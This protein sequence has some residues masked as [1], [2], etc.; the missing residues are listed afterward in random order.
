MAPEP[1]VVRTSVWSRSPTA[2]LTV[3][4]LALV[5]FLTLVGALLRTP[6]GSTLAAIDTEA[7]RTGPA[8]ERWSGVFFQDQHVGY[9]VS[10]A[11]EAA[12]GG[13]LYEE[14]SLFRVASLG[15]LQEVITAG[16]AVV[17]ST[18]ALRQ[19]DFF[20]SADPVRLA[21]RGEVQGSEIVM[22]VDQA[23]T[24]SEVRFPVSAPPHVGM[25][26]E[27]RIRAETLTVGKT[28]QV[29][30]FDPVSLA[31]G[32]MVI[33]VTDV[34]V[35]PNSEEAYWL[36]SRFGDIVTR[37]LVLPNGETLRQEGA[38]GLSLV[39]MTQEAATDLP[40][41][42]GSVDLIAMSAVPL[43]GT[44]RFDARKVRHLAVDIGGV[45]PDHVRNEPPLQTVTG[46]RIV[47]D[48]PFLEELPTLPVADR[49]EPVWVEATLTLPATNEEMI[50]RAA[51][52]VG[53]APDRLAAVER[54]ST[55][56][57]DKVEKV[58]TLSVP[59]GLEVLHTMRGDCNEH[60]ALF[61]S[62]ARAVG[63]P[64]R[65]AAGVVFS[66]RS[67]G[68]AAFYYH[69]WPEVLLGGATGW[70]PVDPTL[71][72]V[73]AD[74]THIKLAEGDL[75]RQIEIMGSMGKIRFTFVEAR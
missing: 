32:A 3:E 34:E 47:I 52:I 36:E 18:G 71:G 14:R 28:F 65:I 25:S 22:A 49:S 31:E 66:D 19:F 72:Q 20:M 58:P 9:A 57:H 8:R 27:S 69:A 50:D 21:A 13:T 48:V 68:P 70:I 44:W 67:G 54:L 17:D 33:T 15:Q 37:S 51:R 35:L 40:A 29:P 24:V 11:S 64:A 56:V 16:H 6:A 42:V 55:W 2:L 30:Y 74:A 23:G 62:L 59:N 12:G 63:I 46:D 7:L 73:P 61:V 45:T 4:V 43:A 41:D 53:D 26:L 75:A 1:L 10:R 5:A 38:L 39:R 60:T